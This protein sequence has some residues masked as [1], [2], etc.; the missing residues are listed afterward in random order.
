MAATPPTT[1]PAMAPTL[2]L[3]PPPPSEASDV[4]AEA[5]VP[6]DVS[7]EVE[8]SD[9]VEESDEVVLALGSF[10]RRI[11]EPPSTEHSRNV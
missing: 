8:D 5:A 4:V 2:E 7:S 3:E 1:P 9:E 6:V 11:P 10:S